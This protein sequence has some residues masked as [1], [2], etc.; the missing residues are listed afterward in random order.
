[1]ILGL[2]AVASTLFLIAGYWQDLANNLEGKLRWMAIAFLCAVQ[3]TLLLIFKLYFFASVGEGHDG[4]GVNLKK[5][6]YGKK[7]EA[8][9][10]DTK[11]P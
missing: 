8:P 2:S 7:D 10:P 9:T 3:L 6:T 4:T 11:T 1:V 5:I